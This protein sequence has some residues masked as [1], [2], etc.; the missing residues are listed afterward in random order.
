M[1]TEIEGM[2]TVVGQPVY[3]HVG[4]LA[5]A[6]Q[7]ALAGAAGAPGTW[8]VLG[9]ALV[10]IQLDFVRRKRPSSRWPVRLLWLCLVVVLTGEVMDAL[11]YRE[12]VGPNLADY[13]AIMTPR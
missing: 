13:N 6:R 1:T 4:Y 2:G 8:L 3:G 7:N 12:R 11:V 10:A 5:A 9:A